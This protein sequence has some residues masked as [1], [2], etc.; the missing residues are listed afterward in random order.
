MPIL[1]SQIITRN[2]DNS[3]VLR[4]IIK[5]SLDV[6]KKEPIEEREV[7]KELQLLVAVFKR[8]KLFWREGEEKVK[9]RQMKN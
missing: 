3:P 1:M 5:K 8:V 9:K 4:P 2:E 6:L 7:F